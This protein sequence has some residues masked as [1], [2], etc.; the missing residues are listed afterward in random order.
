MDTNNIRCRFASLGGVIILSSLPLLGNTSQL[1]DNSIHSRANELGDFNEAEHSER[2]LLR[3]QISK[4]PALI[5][6]A[7]AVGDLALIRQCVHLGVNLDTT[8]NGMTPLKVSVYH[9]QFEAAE[10]LVEAG[11][12]VDDVAEHDLTLL[13][14]ACLLGRGAR[15]VKLF[16]G[17]GAN[18][19]A[20][21]IAFRCP[22]HYAAAQGDADTCKTLINLGA[23]VDVRAKS[24][25]TPLELAEEGGHLEIVELLKQKRRE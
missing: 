5:L 22:I 3:T 1:N 13:H 18:I 10:I 19:N 15:F 9:D 8:Y 2:D 20:R 16:V 4:N 12:A 21:D 24:G 23:S 7:V 25:E 6:D 14:Y 17:A 11:A